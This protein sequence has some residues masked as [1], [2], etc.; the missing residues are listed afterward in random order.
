MKQTIE[1]TVETTETIV[2]RRSRRHPRICP[3]CR[4][5]FEAR[6]DVIDL[7]LDDISQERSAKKGEG[8]CPPD[9]HLSF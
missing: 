4:E 3:Y 6:D 9:E 7:D 1:F 5:S 2:V 8:L